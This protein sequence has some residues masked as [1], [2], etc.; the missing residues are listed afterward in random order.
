MYMQRRG[1]T[2]PLVKPCRV[3]SLRVCHPNSLAFWLAGE[4]HWYATELKG[5]AAATVMTLMGS[6][7]SKAWEVSACYAALR[8]VSVCA[9]AA[10][11]LSN[12]YR[13][14]ALLPGMPGLDKKRIRLYSPL[15]SSGSWSTVALRAQTRTG[16]GL[17]RRPTAQR[18]HLCWGLPCLVACGGVFERLEIAD[19]CSGLARPEPSCCHCPD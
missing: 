2:P 19:S 13:R 17:R 14:E 10:T 15:A 8:P 11:Q 7:Q 12:S 5:L 6:S 9:C 1:R 3:G 16:Q 4:C 18:R